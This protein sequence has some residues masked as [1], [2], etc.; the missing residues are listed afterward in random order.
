MK[1]SYIKKFIKEEDGKHVYNYYRVVNGEEELM[2][3]V[4]QEINESLDYNGNFKISV[5]SI[6]IKDNFELEHYLS[7]NI[8]GVGPNH[9]SWKASAWKTSIF[10]NNS[11]VLCFRRSDSTNALSDG[12]YKD[13]TWIS[14]YDNNKKKHYII[15]LKNGEFRYSSN[16]NK[17]I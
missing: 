11:Y 3:T 5:S 4:D 2:F 8:H 13:R 7:E 9:S 12:L 10:G 16:L 1:E 14:G 6:S 15:E 17:Y